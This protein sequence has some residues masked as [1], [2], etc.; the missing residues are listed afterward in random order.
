MNLISR[1]LAL[2]ACTAPALADVTFVDFS[3][4]AG[5]TLVGG[6]NQSGNALELTANATNQ[7]GAAWASTRQNVTAP[8]SVEFTVRLT[9]TGEGMAFV[10]QRDA[11][12]AIGF[13]GE[14]LGYGGITNAVAI[15]F[16]TFGSL[17][18]QDPSDNHVSIQSGGAGAVSPNIGQSLAETSTLVDLNNG[19]IRTI[20]IEYVP[21]L[22]QVF[23]DNAVTTLQVEL[24]INSQ[25]SLSDGTAWVGFTAGT[26]GVTQRHEVLSW[27]FD[28]QSSVPTG[29]V[30]P[31]AP[32]ISEPASSSTPYNPFDVHMEAGPFVDANNDAHLCT[33]WEIWTMNPS[34]LVWR[35][36]CI[37]GPTRVH[38]HL[39]DGVFL[40]SHAGR[41]ALVPLKSF[42]FRVRFRDDS[43]DPLT[44]WGTWSEKTFQTGA[45]SSFYPY[46]TEDIVGNPAP[47]W[48]F[49]ASTLEP[50]LQ[51]ASPSP[52]I[53]LESFDNQELLSIEANDGMT[54]TVINGPE[55]ADH[56]DAMVRVESGG[57][58]LTL[59]ET[60]LIVVDHECQRTRILIPAISLPPNSFVRYWISSDGATWVAQGG[61]TTPD[62]TTLA[63]GLSLP[64]VAAQP[65]YQIEV[66]ASGFRLPVNIEFIPNAGDQPG[67][68]FAY[69]SE[70][71]GTIKVLKNDGSVGIYASNL[72]NYNPTGQFP[73]SGEQGLG[74]IAIDPVTGDVFAGMLYAQGNPH[75]PKVVR[76]SSTDGG[77]TASSQTTILDMSGESQGQSHF[78]SHLE[79]LDDRTLLV[80]MGDGF[81][82]S[83]A[84]DLN[85]YRGKIL[86]MNLDGTPVPSNPLY[87]GGQITARDYIYV[88]GVRNP[89]GGRF[90]DS[91]GYHY[92]VENGPTVDRFARIVPGRDYLWAGSDS[93]MS[94]FALHNWAP[95]TGPVNLA[96]I[97]PGTFGGSGFPQTK[98][99]HAFV[100][101]S[102]A[103]FASGPQ[104]LGKRITEWE[105]DAQGNKIAGPTTLVE[106]AGTGRASVA[107]LS[108]GPD[109]LYFT[110]LYRDSGNNPT[111]TGAN[112]LRI[113]WIGADLGEC[114][115]LGQSYCGPA[116][117]NSTGLPATIRAR[118]SENVMD[119]DF[120]LDVEQLPTNSFGY[121]LG[122]RTQGFAVAPGGSS[123]NLCLGGTIG[124]FVA[125]AQNSGASGT[126][127]ITVDL[128]NMPSP[129]SSVTVGETWNFQAWFRDF[130]LFVTSNFSD[131]V[132]VTFQ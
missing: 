15:E 129:L 62:F 5:L 132:S 74:G 51:P 90:R 95:S 1:A 105:I 50:V 76:F 37:A 100:S 56:I 110:D 119:N 58:A 34:E 72:L 29:N 69:I 131:G 47:I 7:V 57:A 65:G 24:D 38:S 66:V 96:F 85:S 49:A 80:H 31:A 111:A 27:T 70:L 13:G 30:A 122:S 117:L 124:R 11:V 52:R 118:G 84:R 59:A 68:P 42:R 40:G 98:W 126:F 78:I 12:D 116:E 8:F 88:S 103:T 23:V 17:I 121:C 92:M 44:E 20:R 112:L 71:Y 89:F 79:M 9:G 113:R 18:P 48:K 93:Q 36:D 102:G 109:G 108:A 2:S 73:G 60:D 99:D 45:E 125:Q 82:A 16:D 106:Y 55:L 77:L 120:M 107:G 32:V 114:G 61:Q 54:N 123:G 94:N 25:L 75:Y 26:S 14:A 33:D 41:T 43:G 101:E 63:R 64:W 91:D 35:T 130:Q 22:L 3:S 128:A 86:R 4:T 67:D 53:V 6:A 97:Q 28:E 10:I 39:G 127:N 104:N 19:S 81:V 83:T 87:N 21:G 115:S 46:E